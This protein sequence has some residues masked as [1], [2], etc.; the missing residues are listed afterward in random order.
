MIPVAVLVTELELFS[1]DL[2]QVDLVSRA[3]PNISAFAGVDVANNRLD[4]GA[5][6]SR[7]AMVHLEY[8]GS[9]AVVFDRHSSAKIIGC[10]HS[11]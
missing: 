6:I 3:E 11:R 2:D 8:N 5:Q 1:L 4:E 7:R 9:V 10:R